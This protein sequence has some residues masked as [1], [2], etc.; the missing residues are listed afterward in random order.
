[1]DCKKVKNL[2]SEYLDERL[3]EKDKEAFEEHIS[4]CRSCEDE[5]NAFLDSWEA[6][7]DYAAPEAGGDFTPK[8]VHRI[9]SLIE[10]QTTP[11]LWE[12]ICMV[13]SLKKVALVPAFASLFILAGIAI[14]LLKGHPT[15]MVDSH[16]L[17]NGE[18]AEV[19]RNLKD[20]EII[21]D[22]EIYENADLLENLDLLVDLETVE[23]L[24]EESK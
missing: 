2:I 15:G 10:Q 14:A 6:M 3:S 9:N 21:R 24:E 17:S 13:F 4:G 19:V 18:K 16:G 7:S 5:L 1:M 8:V 12:K 22:L 23:N 20:E 11:S